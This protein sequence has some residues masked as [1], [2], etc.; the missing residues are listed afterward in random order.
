[1]AKP[2]EYSVQVVLQEAPKSF[3]WKVQIRDR[4][5][6]AS[7]K[8]MTGDRKDEMFTSEASKVV[9]AHSI[10]RACSVDELHE[11]CIKL[12]ENSS[13]LD[14]ASSGSL[15]LLEQRKGNKGFQ[16]RPVYYLTVGAL[17]S[18]KLRMKKKNKDKMKFSVFLISTH[19]CWFCSNLFALLSFCEA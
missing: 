15:R 9:H 12:D 4:I 6:V 19:S 14:T 2:V 18:F 3:D 13:R 1:M 8:E 16:G 10:S 17:T 11:L 5:K 7:M